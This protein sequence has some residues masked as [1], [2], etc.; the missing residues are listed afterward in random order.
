M[1]NVLSRRRSFFV[2]EESLVVYIEQLG[3]LVEVFFPHLCPSTGA[4]RRRS[5]DRGAALQ[6]WSRRL[7]KVL[8][9]SSLCLLLWLPSVLL[10]YRQRM[11]L[12]RRIQNPLVSNR[13]LPQV[14]DECPQSV[15]KV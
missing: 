4:G 6:T 9:P 3:V 11:N 8:P 5:P 2:P 13:R 1:G 10:L 14:L 12:T 7:G 15:A